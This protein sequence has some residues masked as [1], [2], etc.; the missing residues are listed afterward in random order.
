MIVGRGSLWESLGRG[1]IGNT[2]ML[3][4]RLNYSVSV[5]QGPSLDSKKGGT[6]TELFRGWILGPGGVSRSKSGVWVELLSFPCSVRG[7]GGVGGK[8]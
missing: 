6:N 7:K 5:P 3:K 4:S 1:G 2:D 8:G